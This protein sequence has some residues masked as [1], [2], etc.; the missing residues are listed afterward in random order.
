MDPIRFNI[1]LHKIFRP[2]DCQYQ[3]LVSKTVFDINFY[4]LQPWERSTTDEAIARQRIQGGKVV[5]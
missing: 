3:S 1:L 4:E 5:E 2:R